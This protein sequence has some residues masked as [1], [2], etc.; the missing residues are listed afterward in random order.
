MQTGVRSWTADNARLLA[1]AV[2]FGALV[3]GAIGHAIGLSHAGDVLWTATIVATLAWTASAVLPA[4]ARGDVGVDVIALLAMTG[5]LVGDELL[6]GAVVAVMLL[7]GNAL[8]AYA[9]GRAQREL[10]A[11]LRRAPHVTHRRV[12]DAW[13]EV[14][15]EAVAVGDELLVR[16]GEVIPVDGLLSSD[17]ASIDASSVT[18]ESLP[19][20][21]RRGEHLRSGTVNAGA[22]L[23]LRAT[24]AAADSSYAALV[25]LVE[26]AQRE[27]PP[28]TR[29]ADR[30]ALVFLPITLVTS[31]L[32][33]ALSGEAVRALAVLVV[34]TP[35]PLIL[36]APIALVAG[37]SR[38]ARAGIVLKGGTALER[39]GS[40]STVLL[41]KTGTL[42]IGRPRIERIAVLDGY[43]E[44]ELLALAAAVEQLSAHA[45]AEGIVD[46]ALRR[47][48][49]LPHPTVPHEDPG[50][51]I[52]A[53]VGD[54][55]VAVGNRAWLRERGFAAA[56]GGDVEDNATPGRARVHVG[57][58]GRIVGAFVMADPLRADATELVAALHDAG[59]RRVAMVT[60]D[61]REVADAVAAEAR[62]DR[63]YAEQSPEDK[64]AVVR[65]LRERSD[66]RPVVMVGDGVNDAP[67]L[68]LADVGIA[69]AGESRTVSSEAADAVITV[70][71]VDRVADAVR[72]GRRTMA[73]AR[74]SVVV[75]I[76]LSSAAMLVAA[77]GYLPPVAGALFQ[78]LIDVGVILNALRALRS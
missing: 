47:G 69:L 48:I 67:A 21:L 10:T 36:A 22:P 19:V 27:R 31:G 35:C 72:V 28:F 60:G 71:R 76:G 41:D 74:Q 13:D 7:G 29:L 11:L 14:P 63:V 9:A 1:A 46:D 64:L 54:H 73:I 32:A 62:L 66:L 55:R 30:Y 51:G 24:R 44:R 53:R 45:L 38:A 18:G 42:T 78:E 77:F 2:G 20:T 5:A 4:L 57:V 59:V 6:A 68:A 23:E 50:D 15:V 70:D 3:S 65:A 58:D 43:H 52:E 61:R 49:T 16:T 25:A 34:A 26:Q 39:L 56:H 33:W 37:L 8:E 40:T 12:G 75:G 17:R